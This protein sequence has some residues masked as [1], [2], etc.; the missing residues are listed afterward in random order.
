MVE[1]V[2]IAAAAARLE[3]C[4]LHVNRAEVRL[5][6]PGGHAVHALLL[7]DDVLL[8]A[9]RGLKVAQRAQQRGQLL[10][11]AQSILVFGAK[12]ALAP[13][14]HPFKAITGTAQVAGPGLRARLAGKAAQKLDVVGADQPL[15]RAGDFLV[16]GQCRR[17]CPHVSL[18]GRHSRQHVE[19][20]RMV[21]TEQ[22]PASNAYR[23][24]AWSSLPLWRSKPAR[25]ARVSPSRRWRK[26][27]LSP[28]HCSDCR[29]RPCCWYGAPSRF[30]S[31]ASGSDT[32]VAMPS[33]DNARAAAMLS[34]SA[35]SAR[36]CH[37]KYPSATQSSSTSK[38]RV[39][40]KRSP[41]R[42]GKA[43]KWSPLNIELVC[44]SCTSSK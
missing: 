20:F 32:A 39:S 11:A 3:D 24:L 7:V 17:E 12:Q 6:S 41:P 1:R 29:W 18:G 8:N 31:A 35:I 23:P 21:I 19:R 33:I 37:E 13:F 9:A 15:P 4:R 25:L 14:E 5:V 42:S 26:V 34:S 36:D 10:G 27:T 30:R 16:Q 44:C 43:A 40:E 2:G 38:V 22:A 28:K